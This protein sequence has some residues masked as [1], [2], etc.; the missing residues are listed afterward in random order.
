[1]NLETDILIIGGGSAG[2]L[3]AIVAKEQNPEA[4]VLVIEK[5]EIHRSG[6][7]AMGMDALN[8][9]VQP[10][11]STPELYLNS[12]LIATDGVLD[13]KPSYV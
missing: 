1:M 7:I 9:V 5:G 6:S 10:G 4:K 13:Y 11:L 2:S 8:I 12:A 3:A